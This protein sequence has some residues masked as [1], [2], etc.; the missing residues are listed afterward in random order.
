[1]DECFQT[2]IKARETGKQKEVGVLCTRK[3]KRTCESGSNCKS[4]G[5]SIEFMPESR[6]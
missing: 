4:R 2:K 1:M 5:R 6:S 3:S